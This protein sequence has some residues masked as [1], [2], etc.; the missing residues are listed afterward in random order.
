MNKDNLNDYID[1]INKYNPEV[2]VSY[3]SPLF[4][5]AKF[6]LRNNIQM[7]P[8]KSIITGAEGLNEEQR[9]VI[10]KAFKCPAYNTYGSRET[11]LIGAECQVQNG[12]HVNI[13]HLVVET[14]DRNLETIKEVPGEVAV[15]DLSNYGMPFIR[16]INGDIATLTDSTCSCKNPLPMMK[17]INGRKLDVLKSSDG[18]LIPG[19]FFPHLMKDQPSVIKYQVIQKCLT[20]LNLN[21]IT[22]DGFSTEH[23][24]EILSNFAELKTSLNLNINIVDDI[25]LTKSGKHRVTICEV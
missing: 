2:I 5:L 9:Q 23:R 17:M 3:T 12:F 18:S 20:Q 1:A 25:E 8:I 14:L 16:Y 6:I 22:D 13:D 4:M 7:C 21:I 24:S 19:E 10:E 11:M 15:T